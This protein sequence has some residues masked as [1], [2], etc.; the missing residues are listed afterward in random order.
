MR[1]GPGVQKALDKVDSSRGGMILHNRVGESLDW[2]LCLPE[3]FTR[4]W[5]LRAPSDRP[6]TPQSLGG[7]GLRRRLLPTPRPVSKLFRNGWHS[8][9]GGGRTP[10]ESMKN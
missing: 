5:E 8:G 4:S 1:R 10:F 6:G 2:T 7:A 9:S 3:L